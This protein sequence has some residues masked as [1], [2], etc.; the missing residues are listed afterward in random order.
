MAQNYSNYARCHRT[1]MSLDERGIDATFAP[2]NQLDMA[3]AAEME[4]LLNEAGVRGARARA[5]LVGTAHDIMRRVEY[6]MHRL[7]IGDYN[8]R[9]KKNSGRDQRIPGTLRRSIYWQVFNATGGDEQK[10]K[11][12]MDAIGQYVELAVQGGGPARN[13][14]GHFVAGRAK[15]GWR[16]KD[17]GLPSPI[18]RQNYGKV[19]MSRTNTE[20]R[21]LKRAAKPFLSGELRLHGRMLFDRLVRHYGYVGNVIIASALDV[22]GIAKYFDENGR[23]TTQ[24]FDKNGTLNN[25]RL[26]DEK[27]GILEEMKRNRDSDFIALKSSGWDPIAG[28][29]EIDTRRRG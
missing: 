7:Q 4:E 11:F 17:G 20:G 24:Q 13:G 2:Y 8:L 3:T 12:W 1:S 5:A 16:V 21:T 29:F 25:M 22:R 19:P 10:L 27:G 26:W 28:N 9:A 23:N 15:K 14:D 18:R 6:N